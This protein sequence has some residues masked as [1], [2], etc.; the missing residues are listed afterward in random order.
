[1]NEIINSIQVLGSGCPTCKQFFE[2]TKKVVEELKINVQTDYISDITKMIE[3]GVMAGPA[4]LVNG[5]L[6][7]AGAGHSEVDI[8]NALTKNI[9]K[10]NN[11]SDCFC[12]NC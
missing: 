3:I 9:I 5:Q 2:L 12:N 8:K 4:L 6:V 10:N 1:M 11:K 7:L